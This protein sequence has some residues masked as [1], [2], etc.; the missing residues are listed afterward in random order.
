MESAW[1][2]LSPLILW[3][4]RPLRA[5]SSFSPCQVPASASVYAGFCP[6][7]QVGRQIHPTTIW[8]FDISQM[9]VAP[10]AFDH[11]AGTDRKLAW[12]TIDLA[13]HTTLPRTPQSEKIRLGPSANFVAKHRP[14]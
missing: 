1:N 6:R 4:L 12:N 8:E 13:T 2:E 10:A 7:R 5:G 14:K 9:N 3:S 11:I